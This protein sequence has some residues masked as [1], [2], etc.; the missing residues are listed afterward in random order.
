ME[1]EIGG[2]G[3]LPPLHEAVPASGIH[4]PYTLRQSRVG[5]MVEGGLPGWGP[6]MTRV[7]RWLGQGWA[8]PL[9][10][11]Y[12]CQLAGHSWRTGDV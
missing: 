2:A 3:P 1:S 10:S 6:E 9:G 4:L 7:D 12:F 8:G 11:V 5:D